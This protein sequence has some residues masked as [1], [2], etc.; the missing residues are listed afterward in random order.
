MGLHVA[1]DVVRLTVR[2]RISVPGARILVMGLTFKEDCP[3]VRNTRAVDV[4]RELADYGAT[5]EVFD[6]WVDPDK[7]ESHHV[8]GAACAA[9]G[10]SHTKVQPARARRAGLARNRP[11]LRSAAASGRWWARRA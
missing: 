2:R 11:V 1:A 7:K 4:V 9:D 6:R 8:G 10:T 3:D 5:V